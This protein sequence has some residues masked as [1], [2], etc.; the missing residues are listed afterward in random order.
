MVAHVSSGDFAKEVLKAKGIVVVDF[1]AEWCGPCKRYGPEFEKASA[2]H[3]SKAKFFKLNVD[4]AQ[5]IAAQFGVMSIPTTVF[6]KDGVQVD[7]AI[8]IFSSAQLGER[9]ARIH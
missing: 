2:E 1:W 7:E 9:I 8:G 4:E 6:F 5:D 3:G